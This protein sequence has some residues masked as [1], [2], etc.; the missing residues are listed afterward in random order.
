MVLIAEISATVSP[1]SPNAT[2]SGRFSH[3]AVNQSRADFSELPGTTTPDSW[4]SAK[5]VTLARTLAH[6]AKHGYA[7]VLH[8]YVRE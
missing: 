4:N 8:R 5:V 6:P 7:P 2:G 3:L 1:V